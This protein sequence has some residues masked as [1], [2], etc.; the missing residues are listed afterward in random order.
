MSVLS[1]LGFLVVA[2]EAVLQMFQYQQLWNSYRVVFEALDGERFLFNA[3]AGD[4]AS[5]KPDERRKAFASKAHA[6][7]SLG[8]A[9]RTKIKRDLEELLKSSPISV[10]GSTDS[11]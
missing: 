8:Q 1:V 4:Y 11:Q 5:M 3:H 10:P 9:E 2:F 7:I 6:I